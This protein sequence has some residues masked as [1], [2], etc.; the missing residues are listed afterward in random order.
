MA[1]C[2]GHEHKGPNKDE[3]NGREE[4]L[5]GA[6]MQKRINEQERREELRL[7]SERISGGI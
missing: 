6:G 7:G 3:E 4:I 5:E 2:K 1:Q